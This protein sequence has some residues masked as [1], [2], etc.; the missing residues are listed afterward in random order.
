M[1]ELHPADVTLQVRCAG[2]FRRLGRGAE[3]VGVLI[4]ARARGDIHEGGLK[5]LAEWLVKD[6][7]FEEAHRVLADLL[8]RRPDDLDVPLYAAAALYGL[9]RRDEALAMLR[10]TETRWR[11][12]KRWNHNVAYRLGTQ[13]VEHDHAEAA[14]TWLEEAVRLR[15][16]SRGGRGGADSTLG[17]YYGYL[18]RARVGLGRTDDA[19]DAASAAIVAWGGNRSR[20]AKALAALEQVLAAAPDLDD[21]VA[22][23]EAKVDE[24][25]LDAPVIRKTLASVF[26]KKAEH[27]KAARQLYAARE[28]APEDAEIHQRL[29]AACDAL[30]R[31]EEALDALL[32]SLAMAPRNLDAAADLAR[33]FA[34]AGRE[35]EAERAL[36]NLVEPLPHEAA[37]HRRLAEARE[38]TG[39]HES[40]EVQWQQVVRT[41]PLD[42]T[43]WLALAR[44]QIELERSPQARKTLEHVLT[45]KWEDRFGDVKKEASGLMT[46]IP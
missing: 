38:S 44:C 24:T 40:A 11:E 19:V 30:G 7:R 37:G 29:V 42:P 46:R 35:D 27:A 1:V 23:Y 10:A 22:R 36:T 12:A 16:E 34:D 3:A 31:P 26:T 4:A 2:Y 41:D 32:A 33:R 18:A 25:G 20:R 45:S 5:T 13:A 8:E 21:Y 9:E 39:D 43:G 15:I 14:N 17:R 6:E 28:I